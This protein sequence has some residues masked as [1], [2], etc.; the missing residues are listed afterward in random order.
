MRKAIVALP[1]VASAL[2]VSIVVILLWMAGSVSG[3]RA[4]FSSLEIA[5]KEADIFVALN[6]DPTSPQWLAVNDSLDAIDAKDPIRRSIDEALARVNLDFEEDI[7][8]VA[9]DE[10]FFSV[11]DA[12]ELAGDGGYVAGSRL[13]NASKA[14]SV[15]DSLRQRAESEGEKLEEMEYEGVTIYYTGLPIPRSDIPPGCEFDDRG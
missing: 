2:I 11:P 9:G 5:P 10:A 6:T 7:L 8:P 4:R 12:S 3:E 1:A 15:F 14:Q 13:R